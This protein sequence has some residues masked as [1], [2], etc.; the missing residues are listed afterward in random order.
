MSPDDR[1]KREAGERLAAQVRSNQA[2]RAA[3]SQR[4]AFIARTNIESYSPAMGITPELH[5]AMVAKAKELQ[6]DGKIETVQQARESHAVENA[7]ATARAQL[8][9]E[10][11]TLPG[12]EYI[13]P[14]DPDSI[15]EP[16]L[17]ARL[18]GKLLAAQPVTVKSK[19][20]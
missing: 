7:L 15:D 11:P 6:K 12:V 20:R 4:K 5:R 18:N 10:D 19:H 9:I 8:G 17:E 1:L 16:P 3:E 13:A 2:Q 14:F